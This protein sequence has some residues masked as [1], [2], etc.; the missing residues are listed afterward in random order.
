MLHI[1]ITFALIFVHAFLG[2][3][4]PFSSSFSSSSLIEPRAID[5]CK[6]VNGVLSILSALKAPATSFC[7]SLLNIA[8]STTTTSFTLA[9]RTTTVLTTSTLT[10]I[11]ASTAT[12][13]I[14]QT[15]LVS[16]TIITTTILTDRVTTT[17]TVTIGGGAKRAVMPRAPIATPAAL[18]IFAKSILSTACSCLS[19]RVP[20]ITSTSTLPAATATA[21]STIITTTTRS[22]A[23]S[24][25]TDT[26]TTTSTATSTSVLTATTTSTT[27]VLATCRASNNACECS[28]VVP[29]AC[30]QVP[31]SI[32]C[33]SGVC[34][35]QFSLIG[36]CQ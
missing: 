22:T 28:E 18:A 10:K 17:L 20:L 9:G 13:R 5:V 26:T 35:S 19:I 14:T 30:T 15:A 8:P 3:G 23:A 25:E 7:G 31:G 32:L 11:D 36:F 6:N 24:T 4:S 29:G 12:T 27:Q 33:C 21:T 1:S 16:T 2:L 34:L